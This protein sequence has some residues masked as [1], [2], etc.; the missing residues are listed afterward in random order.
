MRTPNRTSVAARAFGLALLLAGA[1]TA[2]SARDWPQWL[3][4]YYQAPEPDRVVTAAFELSR[5]GYFD[6]AGRTTEAIGFFAGVFQRNP[7]RV[8]EWTAAFRDLPRAHQRLMAAALWCAGSP[9]GAEQLERL[10]REGR[11]SLRAEIE[12]LVAKPAPELAST[13]VRSEASL[14]LQWGA[15]LATGEAQ[16]IVSVLMAL[17]SREPGVSGRAREV[18]AEKAAAHPRVYAICQAQL[19][20]QPQPIREQLHALLSEA[21][22]QRM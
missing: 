19:E 1:A 14:N 9:R 17:G 5:S 7:E 3:S 6:E 8:A 18:L 22:P 15:F 13:P 11:S 16:H 20:K 4:Q 21:Q 12:Q 10:A 2:A